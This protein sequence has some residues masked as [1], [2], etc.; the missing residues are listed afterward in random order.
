MIGGGIARSICDNC[1]VAEIDLTD[2]AIPAKLVAR[3]DMWS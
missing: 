3:K 2:T 1:G